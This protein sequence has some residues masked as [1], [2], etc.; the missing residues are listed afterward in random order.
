MLLVLHLGMNDPSPS[1]GDPIEYAAE[2]EIGQR[3]LIVALGIQAQVALS[4]PRVR[5]A[6]S[7]R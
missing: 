4:A 7:W 6:T 5:T 1:L 3:R 2:P